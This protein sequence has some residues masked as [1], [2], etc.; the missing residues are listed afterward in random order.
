MNRFA[1]PHHFA[2]VCIAIPENNDIVMQR[3]YTKLKTC[4]KLFSFIDKLVIAADQIKNIIHTN[5]KQE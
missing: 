2:L 5:I 4:N 3:C 1:V